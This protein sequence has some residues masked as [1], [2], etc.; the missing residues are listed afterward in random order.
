MSTLL[1]RLAG[2]M[3]SWGTDSR[4]D[5]RFTGREPS[6]SGV[7]GMLCAALG[8]PRE[9]RPGDGFPPLAEL[10]ALRM[11]VRIDRAGA[12]LVD[13][14]T[15]GGSHRAEERYGVINAVGRSLSTVQS[16]R[17]YLADAS[18]LVGL[19][20]DDALLRRLDAAV[21]APVWQ[22][23]LGRKAFVPGEPVRLPDAGPDSAWWGRTLE[24]ALGLVDG[25]PGYP[26]AGGV[27]LADRVYVVMDTAPGRGAEV[28]QDVP[29][30]FASRRFGRRYVATVPVAMPLEVG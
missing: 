27:R 7:I 3:Q 25:V 30:D 15:A 10:A 9:E 29:L 2:P 16:R 19:E 11:G 12:L 24:E 17:Y 5:I 14:Q 21:A 23:C 6:K 18:F 1:L 4:F 20:G 22:L 28:R 26:L 8:K 13:Y